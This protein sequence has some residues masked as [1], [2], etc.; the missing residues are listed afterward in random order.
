MPTRP[1]PRPSGSSPVVRTGL[2]RALAQAVLKHVA[3]RNRQ[4]HANPAQSRTRAQHPRNSLALQLDVALQPDRIGHFYREKAFG[5]IDV[6]VNNAAT[7]YLAAVEEG[8]RAEIRAMFETNFFGLAALIG[9]CCPGCA[10]AGRGHHHISSVGGLL[11][12][13]ARVLQRHQVRRGRSVRGAGERGG[14]ARDSRPR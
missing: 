7:A 8:R 5:R 4:P 9:A 11:G 14:T 6:L 1:N 13:P 3:S 12:N 2:G 10:P